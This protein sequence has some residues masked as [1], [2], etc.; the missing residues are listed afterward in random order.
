VDI[1]DQTSGAQHETAQPTVRLRVQ[2]LD[3]D[4]PPT[5]EA[6]VIIVVRAGESQVWAAKPIGA[7]AIQGTV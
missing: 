7:N 6:E 4:I 2:I 1:R 5:A 3:E